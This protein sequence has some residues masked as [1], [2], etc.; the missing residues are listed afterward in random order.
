MLA[1]IS[2]LYTEISTV[3]AGQAIAYRPDQADSFNLLRELDAVHGYWIRM[4]KP[5]RLEVEGSPLAPSTPVRLS[6]GWNLI[7]FLPA[8]ALTVRDALGSIRGDFA[9]VRGFDVEAR[10]MLPNT[11]AEMNTLHE[12]RPGYGYLINMTGPATLVYP[13][14]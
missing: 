14:R 7:S 13:D 9:E 5:A 1:P 6:S 8:R 10:S 12:M 3:D 2:G 11:P 4:L